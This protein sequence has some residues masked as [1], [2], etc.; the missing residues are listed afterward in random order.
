M[1]GAGFQGRA[2]VA[3][4]LI[5]HGLDPLGMHEDGYI[6]MHRACWAPTEAHAETVKVFIDA[7]VPYNF[8]SKDLKACMTMT[9]NSGTIEVLNEAAKE[10][11]ATKDGN[12][13]EL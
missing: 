8:E 2:E 5:D 11:A 13:D 9:K 4:I 10:A 12:G 1:H 7:G 3:K 6:A